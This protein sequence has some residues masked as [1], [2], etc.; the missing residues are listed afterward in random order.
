MYEAPKISAE[1]RTEIVTTSKNA[2]ERNY[3]AYALIALFG[4]SRI[5]NFFSLL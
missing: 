2:G 3:P 5:F 1:N 4:M